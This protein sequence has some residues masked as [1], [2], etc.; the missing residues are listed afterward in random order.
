MPHF[1]WV[2]NPIEV[3]NVL[4]TLP[5][6]MFASAAFGIRGSG[7]GKTVLL[8]EPLIKL[9]GTFPIHKQE[10][11]DCVSHGWGLAVDI[12][13]AVEIVLGGENEQFM[14]ETATEFL[15]HCG[16]VD[17]GGGQLGNE[18]GSLG[19]WQ[20]KAVQQ[21]GTIARR[22]FASVD[23]TQYSG[24]RAKEWGSPR[25]N[26]PADV[27]SEGREHPVKN[28]SLVTSYEE[29]RDAIANGYPVP[30]CS[31]QGFAEQRDGEGFS[32][33][34]GQWAHCMCFIAVD[35]NP[36]RPGLL[37]MNSWGPDW[38]SGPKRLGQP[39][40]SFWVD[41]QTADRMLKNRDSF[42]PSQYDGYKAQQLPDNFA[43]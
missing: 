7:A 39:D 30:V 11:G 6:P 18:D 24:Q 21:Q 40:G 42:A 29:A 2:P 8:F 4:A 17:I 14:A 22:K 16:R 41:A 3:D 26:I 27:D 25:A 37:C 43:W 35:D 12:L 20:A 1:G 19:A 15:Y 32:R 10:I 9:L 31:M 38:I 13:K 33:P 34:Q 36:N 5:H 28:V 23:L